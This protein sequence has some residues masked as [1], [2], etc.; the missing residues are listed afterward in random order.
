VVVT[1][2]L[3]PRHQW[4]GRQTER[5]MEKKR[6]KANSSR[7]AAKGRS[8]PLKL[9]TECGRSLLSR[10]FSHTFRSANCTF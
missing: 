3:A 6:E 10:I 5:E 4:G 9:N 7:K 2:R 8:G 1:G